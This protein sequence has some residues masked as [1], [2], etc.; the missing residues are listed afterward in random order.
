MSTSDDWERW[1]HLGGLRDHL[2]DHPDRD[3]D[4]GG[5]QDAEPGRDSDDVLRRVREPMALDDPWGSIDIALTP[6][7]DAQ[8]EHLRLAQPTVLDELLDLG[9]GADADGPGSG[10]GW[11]SDPATEVAEV[12]GAP[13][14]LRSVFDVLDTIDPDGDT[15]T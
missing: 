7:T 13:D 3:D 5:P 11:A 14:P 12:A 6:L 4:A 1:L 9:R 10:S 15:S 8:R 2:D